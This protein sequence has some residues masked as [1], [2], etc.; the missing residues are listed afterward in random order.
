MR[1]TEVF[2]DLGN[3]WYYQDDYSFTELFHLE[4]ITTKECL[5]FGVL[6]VMYVFTIFH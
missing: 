6:N 5:F 4:T 2:Y 1:R 3:F